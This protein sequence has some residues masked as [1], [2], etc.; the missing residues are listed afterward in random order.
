MN[1]AVPSPMAF[2]P[3]LVRGFGVAGGVLRYPPRSGW[4]VR[5]FVLLQTGLCSNVGF[6]LQRG[7]A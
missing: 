3:M 4:A 5:G 6:F 2:L 7:L 1:D